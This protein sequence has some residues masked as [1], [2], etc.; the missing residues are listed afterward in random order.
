MVLAHTGF[1]TY[2][3][4][5][6]NMF[7][8]PL[9]FFLSG[10]CFKEKYINN[11]FEFIKRKI[12][13]IY[14]PYVKYSL[15]FLLL[16]NVFFCLNIYNGEYGFH[17]NVSSLY[18]F[19]DFK[20]RAFNIIIRMGGHEQL[21][22]GYW[23]MKSLFYGSLISYLIIKFSSRKPLIQI[24][25]VYILGILFYYLQIR[26]PLI[27][28][29][30]REILASIFFICG[31]TYNRINFSIESKYQ[32]IPIAA[33]LVVCGTIYWKGS[34]LDM[35]V[36]RMLPYTVTAVMGTIM[37]MSI[38]NYIENSNLQ[39]K[40]LLIYIGNNTFTVLTWHFLC[41]KLVNLLI[42]IIYELDIKQMAEFPI[43]ENY[44]KQG[45]WII[46]LLIGFL[47]LIILHFINNHKMYNTIVRRV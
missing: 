22:G 18:N 4:D 9:F 25:G 16:H 29:G 43:I 3:N 34:F 19:S 8:M 46:Y 41:F 39:I 21:L 14:R 2:G 36:T 35:D 23:F 27:G 30:A 31:Y 44:S 11:G 1:S 20:Y 5:Y 40:K 7:H 28:I 12:S 6:I 13:G 47:P 10:Y 17:G 38:S 37:I 32:I 24:G 33:L 26:V 15:I 45:W 42:I